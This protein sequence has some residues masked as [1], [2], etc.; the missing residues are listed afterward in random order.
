MKIEFNLLSNAEDSIQRAIELVAWGDDQPEPRRLKQ[1]VQSIAHGVELLLKERLKRV[2][3]CLIW[4]NVDKYPSLN[5]RTVTS[6]GAMSRLTSIGGLKFETADLELIRSLRATRNAIEHYAWN[7]TKHEAEII[8]GRALE[9]TFHFAKTELNY[10]FFGYQTRKEDT[11]HALLQ[12]NEALASAMAK[13]VFTPKDDNE[14][15]PEVCF[16]CRARAVDPTTHACRLCGHWSVSTD[17]QDDIP[18]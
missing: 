11:F 3:P 1:A 14:P 2:H 15:A 9:F 7:T 12:S 6:E 8:V 10:E 13:R 5:A 4:E 17:M 16:I 18:F